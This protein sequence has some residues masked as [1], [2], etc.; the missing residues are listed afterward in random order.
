VIEGLT[1]VTFR[2]GVISGTFLLQSPSHFPIIEP[3]ISEAASVW[4]PKA[5]ST[6]FT[7]NTDYLENLRMVTNKSDGTI[8]EVWFPRALCTRWRWVGE[9]KN[10]QK[11][12]CEFSAVLEDGV[13]VVSTDTSPW[14]LRELA[15]VS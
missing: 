1:R 11:V 3:G 6:L 8:T 7:P 13:A 4:T 9:D 12:E 14:K 15:T 5:A 10:E 2:G